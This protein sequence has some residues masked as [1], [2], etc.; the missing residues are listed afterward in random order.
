MV[1]SKVRRV[2]KG[3]SERDP[4][5]NSLPI[6]IHGVEILIDHPCQQLESLSFQFYLFLTVTI[7]G[8]SVEAVICN[9]YVETGGEEFVK[10]GYPY[11]IPTKLPTRMQ[12]DERFFESVPQRR[13]FLRSRSI[14]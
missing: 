7:K 12:L 13:P 2:G 5:P 6:R 3:E 4:I 9:I 14:T 1:F 10:I 8:H 11:A